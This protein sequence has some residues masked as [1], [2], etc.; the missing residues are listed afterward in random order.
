MSNMTITE[1][2]KR[3]NR[4]IT[5]DL[6]VMDRRRAE[7]LIA[8]LTL[9]VSAMDGGDERKASA[10]RHQSRVLI[11]EMSR[12]MMGLTMQQFSDKIATVNG[13]VSV[14][15][16]IKEE[17]RDKLDQM[18]ESVAYILDPI[19]EFIEDERT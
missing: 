7:M 9:L 10:A 15:D 11:M 8:S 13:T 17:F 12:M 2:M 18:Y 3:D 6:P 19:D 5:E 16:S 14:P 1:E 4:R